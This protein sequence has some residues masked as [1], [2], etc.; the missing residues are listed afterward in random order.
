MEEVKYESGV[1]P[2]GTR[3][4]VGL[5]LNGEFSEHFNESQTASL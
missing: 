5:N 2:E 1:L 3:L 4:L